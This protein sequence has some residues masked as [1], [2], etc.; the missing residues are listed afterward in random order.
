MKNNLVKLIFCIFLLLFHLNAELIFEDNF[1][2]NAR[3]LECDCDAEYQVFI[4]SN[5]TS[6]WIED[7]FG[8]NCKNIKGK[9]LVSL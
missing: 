3:Y 1:Q 9:R 7:I 5:N 8:F 2:K 4:I 6:M